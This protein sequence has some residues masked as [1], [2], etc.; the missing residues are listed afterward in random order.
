[1]GANLDSE[2]E[3]HSQQLMEKRNHSEEW[4]MG[5]AFSPQKTKAT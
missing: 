5:W 1:M 3:R 4:R 2:Q